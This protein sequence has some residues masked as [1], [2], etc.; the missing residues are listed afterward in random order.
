MC[1]TDLNKRAILFELLPFCE[2]EWKNM[3][4]TASLHIF[5]T[6]QNDFTP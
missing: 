2:C 4:H 5:V 6:R 1:I 3:K